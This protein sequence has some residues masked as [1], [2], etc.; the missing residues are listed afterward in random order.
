MVYD[1][2]FADSCI[3]CSRFYSYSMY[4]GDTLVG[5][6]VPHLTAL[7]AAVVRPRFRVTRTNELGDGVAMAWSSSQ[8]HRGSQFSGF[9]ASMG[10]PGSKNE[11][12]VPYKAIFCG[13]ILLHRPYIGLIYGRYLQ[14]RILKWPTAGGMTYN[15]Y[16]ST[17]DFDTPQVPGRSIWKKTF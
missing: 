8:F 13:D 17:W 14:F 1:L 4:F 15:H 10:I 9:P 5:R 2:G 16:P 7:Q 12:T 11:G 3:R 6:R